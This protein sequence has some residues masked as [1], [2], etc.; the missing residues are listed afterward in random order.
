MVNIRIFFA[1]LKNIRIMVKNAVY[2][3]HVRRSILVG[4]SMHQLTKIMSGD[5]Y[6]V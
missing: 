4:H 1:A 5:F 6:A 2:V 3:S